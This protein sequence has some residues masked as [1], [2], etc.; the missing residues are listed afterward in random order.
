MTAIESDAEV[1]T[2]E[3]DSSVGDTPKVWGWKLLTYD[4]LPEWAKDNEYIRG[5]YRPILPSFMATF[6]TVFRIHNETGNIWSHLIG[7]LAFIYAAIHVFSLPNSPFM[8][9]YMEKAIFMTFFFGA[10]I[11]LGFSWTFHT[12]CCHSN[13]VLCIFAKLDYSGIALMIMG[14]MMPW[15]YYVFYCDT[16]FRFTYMLI[17]CVIGTLCVLVSQSS[18]FARPEYRGLRA[19]LFAGFGCSALAPTGHTVIQY[20]VKYAVFDC[21]IWCLL[22]MAAF[23]LGGAM[24]YAMQVPE[25]WSPGRFDLVG[26]SHQIFHVFVVIAAAFHMYAIW[27]LH[28]QRKSIGAGCYY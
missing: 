5:H 4:E 1:F 3:L 8:N 17:M 14:S 19:G 26:N 9:P 22:I 20:G 21:F 11:C 25:R 6:S 18:T 15:L 10:I 12:A 16:I 24:I 13:N 2:T 7:F 27:Q 28:L 23:Y